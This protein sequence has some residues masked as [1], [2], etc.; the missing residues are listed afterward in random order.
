[1][2]KIKKNVKVRNF[3][4][5]T[6]KFGISL[7]TLVITIIVIIILAAAV[8]MSLNNNNVIT[9]ASSARYESDRDY[10]QSVLELAV[11]KVA[12]RHQGA[13]DLEEGPINT[14]AMNVNT[15][16][17]EV[18]WE[19]KELAGLSGKIIFGEGTDTD[20]EFYT[21][22]ELPVYGSETTWYV[23]E[24][25]KVVLQT[26]GKIYGAEEVPKAK[27]YISKTESYV[28]YYADIDGDG[29]VDGVIYADL[30]MGNTGDGQWCDE[31][32][33]SWYG[34][35]GKYTIPKIDGTKEYYISKKGFT[36][37]FGTK[38]VITAKGKGNERF[39]VMAL[40]D[41]SEEDYVW[42]NAAYGN[43]SDWNTV[44]SVDFG[45]GKQN[46]EKMI[47]YWNEKKYG[48]HDTNGA[49][50]DVWGQ[51]QSE[52]N[53]GWFV[54]S[55]E[56]LAAFFEELGIDKTNY[57]SFGLSDWYFSSSQYNTACC[58]SANVGYGAINYCSV[59][60]PLQSV[61]LSTIF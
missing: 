9:N 25:G 52:V 3:T 5:L 8:V 22:E 45:K 40:D 58:W 38:D 13:I 31:T 44:T 50:K 12:L 26:V 47:K 4:K 6:Q 7:I 34:E 33:L 17:G 59:G 43:M 42:Y 1:M 28:G 10:V 53:K 23:D 16:T 36:N 49:Y 46:T 27:E 19:S 41:I 15:T 61:R 18:E 2:K 60:G 29:T 21:G 51:I 37:D 24:H 57:S 32:A 39:Y 48:E 54:A 30:A 14:A 20:T 35:Y 55:K 56:E 11:Q